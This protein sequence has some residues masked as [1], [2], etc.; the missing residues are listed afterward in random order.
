MISASPVSRLGT[1][2]F[3]KEI[4]CKLEYAMVRAS[5]IARGK[6]QGVGFRWTVADAAQ[7]LELNGLVRNLNDGTVQIF[8]D[9]P[10]EKITEFVNSIRTH[11][12]VLNGLHPRVDELSIAF[13]GEKGYQKPW[14]TYT[15]FEIDSS[16]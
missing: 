8:L 11:E 13:E 6:V 4:T 7:G 12:G 15:G 14:R 5:L 9:G 10:R 16:R 2:H 3:T 1:R